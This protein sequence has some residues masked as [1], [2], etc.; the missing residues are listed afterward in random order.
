MKICSLSQMRIIVEL[1]DVICTSVDILYFGHD[2]TSVWFK[3]MTFT[4]LP[5]QEPVRSLKEGECGIQE[6]SDS[7]HKSGT[8]D[9]IQEAAPTSP[10]VYPINMVDLLFIFIYIYIY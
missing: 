3:N 8:Q 9:L 1:S 4:C 5:S 7:A 2:F 6:P 10:K